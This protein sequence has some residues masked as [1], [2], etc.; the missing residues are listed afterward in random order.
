MRRL[1]AEEKPPHL[2]YTHTSHN[3]LAQETLFTDSFLPRQTS[4]GLGLFLW[5]NEKFKILYA[6]RTQ[7]TWTHLRSMM[8]I[9]DP[10]ECQFYMEMTRIEHWDTHTLDTKIDGQLYQRTAIS[11]RP[12]AV[13]KQELDS[14]K[15]TNQLIPDLVF[16]SSYLLDCL[17]CQTY[18]LKRNLSPQ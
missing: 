10:L 6:V 1:R 3:F 17:A 14:V 7:L 5:L 2:I 18:I 4:S 15:E 11:R 9:K 12:E 13:I 8:A 16:R